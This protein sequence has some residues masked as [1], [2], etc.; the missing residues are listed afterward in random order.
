MSS[1]QDSRG[2]RL[3]TIAALGLAAAVASAL[4]LAP[5]A[6][7]DTTPRDGGAVNFPNPFT[8]P[9]PTGAVS[10]YSTLTTF[11]HQNAFIASLGTNGRVCATC[12]VPTEGWTIGPADV[13]FRFEATGGT[14]PILR[15][16]ASRAPYFHNGSA[17]DLDEVV[18]FYNTRF[19]LS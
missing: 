17:R 11:S 10:T 15:G 16:L 1:M 9:D 14:E 13:R 19:N 7:A 6:A 4:L 5:P 2:D 18:D 3:G 12:H 8:T